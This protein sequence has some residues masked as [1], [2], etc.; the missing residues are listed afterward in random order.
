MCKSFSS[1]I[2][3]NLARPSDPKA[4]DRRDKFLGGKKMRSVAVLVALL[5]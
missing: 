5:F 4:L 3:D 2:G 1:S